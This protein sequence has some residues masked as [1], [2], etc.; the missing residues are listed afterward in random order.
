MQRGL[1]FK[2]EKREALFLSKQ[3]P[4]STVQFSFPSEAFRA[5]SRVLSIFVGDVKMQ[6]TPPKLTMYPG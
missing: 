4:L 1:R 5:S 6:A 3:L 2:S